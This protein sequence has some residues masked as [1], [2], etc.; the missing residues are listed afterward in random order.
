MRLLSC[1]YTPQTH[2]QSMINP[3][4]L[5]LHTTGDEEE[6]ELDGRIYYHY[7]IITI[8]IPFIISKPSPSTNK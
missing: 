8:I 7:H 5:L 1:I 2:T 3:N 6:A 4:N